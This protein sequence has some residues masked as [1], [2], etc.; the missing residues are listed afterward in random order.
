MF[1]APSGR[2]NHRRRLGSPS[3]HLSTS[4]VTDVLLRRGLS[5]AFPRSS[6]GPGQEQEAEDP[7]QRS[8]PLEREDLRDGRLHAEN[9]TTA[10]RSPDATKRPKKPR[11]CSLRR[12]CK[13]L[14]RRFQLR[15]PFGQKPLY[16]PSRAVATQL[17]TRFAVCR[18]F[19]W[20]LS[21]TFPRPVRGMGQA[22]SSRGHDV[23][24]ARLGSPFAFASPG[25]PV[26]LARDS[27]RSSPIR[28]ASC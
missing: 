3:S 23:P 14:R 18:R 25:S 2:T 9:P 15:G 5:T 27:D 20:R 19:S 8:G 6:R 13:H 11:F 1:V 22:P 26:T 4:F 16:G 12:L 21:T 17:S 7:D 24:F 10:P 28:S